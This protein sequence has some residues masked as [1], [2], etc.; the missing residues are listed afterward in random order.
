M[1]CFLLFTSL[2]NAQQNKKKFILQPNTNTNKL[3]LNFLWNNGLIFCY[4]VNGKKIKIYLKYLNTKP[5]IN[6]LKNILKSRKNVDFSAKQLFKLNSNKFYLIL[7]TCGIKP[8]I[9]CK[10]KNLGGKPFLIIN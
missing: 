10:N 6:S 5:T 3:F 1:N 9:E 4:L 7:T 8:L 2:K